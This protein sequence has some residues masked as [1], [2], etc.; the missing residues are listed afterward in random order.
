MQAHAPDIAAEER[1][2]GDGGSPAQHAAA[3]QRD[4]AQPGAPGQRQA[5]ADRRAQD[6][7]RQ[8]NKKNAAQLIADDGQHAIGSA[9]ARP[10]A[11]LGFAHGVFQAGIFE[12]GA[13]TGDP[14]AQ[15]VGQEALPPL[16]TL[17]L[18][19]K[20]ARSI[21][22]T[23]TAASTSMPVNSSIPNVKSPVF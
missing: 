15:P 2:G 12:H 10:R 16:L 8:R 11:L 23:A 14:S 22:T 4:G 6:R 17:I 19:R 18:F 9:Q 5:N 3:G 20:Y 7:Q 1:K 21:S 13:S